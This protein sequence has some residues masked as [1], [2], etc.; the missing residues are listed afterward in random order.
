MPTPTDYITGNVQCDL[1]TPSGDISGSLTIGMSLG[2]PAPNPGMS[3][4]GLSLDTT[5]PSLRY[6][7]TILQALPTLAEYASDEVNV[8]VF[9]SAAGYTDI[10]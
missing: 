3:E 9:N 5:I 7:K 4:L 6:V 1:V 8:R 10:L 2:A